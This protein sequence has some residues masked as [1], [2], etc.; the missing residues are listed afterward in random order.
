MA[1]PPKKK[2][3]IRKKQSYVRHVSVSVSDYFHISYVSLTM[4]LAES[5]YS[6]HACHG[7]NTVCSVNA[8]HSLPTCFA[9]YSSNMLRQKPRQWLAQ[10]SVRKRTHKALQATIVECIVGANQF[11]CTLCTIS[12]SHTYGAS[13]T[14][15]QSCVRLMTP[16]VQQA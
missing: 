1:C 10:S 9:Q 6:V 3:A 13:K 11:E 7:H 4:S 12:V 5:R 14:L 16:R 15:T 2:H 8:D